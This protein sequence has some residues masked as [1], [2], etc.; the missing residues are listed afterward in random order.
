MESLKHGA[1]Y[2]IEILTQTTNGIVVS[3][4]PYYIKTDPTP[5]ISFK[6]LEAG[7]TT[8]AGDFYVENE[9]DIDN[10]TIKYAIRNNR[11]DKI[12]IASDITISHNGVHSI[13]QNNL[14]PDTEYTFG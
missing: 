3:S 6:N 7:A 13:S 1:T 8:V 14:T 11:T 4:R 2:E 5:S 9:K 10:K 12:D